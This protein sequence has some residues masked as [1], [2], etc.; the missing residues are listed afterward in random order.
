MS[1]S[2]F[3]DTNILLAKLHICLLYLSV[4]SLFSV[5]TFKNKGCRSNNANRNGTCYTQQEC[6]EKGG[7]SA[8]GCASG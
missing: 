7:V 1:R 8:G 4:F 5:V 3:W 6:S 2:L